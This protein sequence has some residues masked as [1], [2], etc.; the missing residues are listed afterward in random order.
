M[1]SHARN[2]QVHTAPLLVEVTSNLCGYIQQGVITPDLI[3]N[4][5]FKLYK[6]KVAKF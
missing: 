2:S 4:M 1:T 5:Q 6:L 3:I